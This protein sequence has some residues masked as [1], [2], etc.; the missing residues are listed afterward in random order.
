MSV[1]GVAAP[2]SSA[3]HARL[4]GRRALAMR[5]VTE[6]ASHRLVVPNASVSK[7]TRARSR[8]NCVDDT[9]HGLFHVSASNVPFLVGNA[10]KL[11]SGGNQ[12]LQSIAEAVAHPAD[13]AEVNRLAGMLLLSG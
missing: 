8:R 10:C 4:S 1:R 12:R 13:G 7:E 6:L 5:T 9:A 11:S 3:C 2:A